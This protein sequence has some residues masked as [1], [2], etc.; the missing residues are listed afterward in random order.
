[1][2]VI[3][4]VKFT[5]DQLRRC[6]S[7]DPEFGRN[8]INFRLQLGD[9]SITTNNYFNIDHFTITKKVILVEDNQHHPETITIFVQAGGRR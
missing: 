2:G 1:P 9:K 4:S 8:E 3:D 6:Y 7:T 5:V